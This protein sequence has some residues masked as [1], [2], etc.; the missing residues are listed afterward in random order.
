MTKIEAD[1]ARLAE[2]Y[3]R[4]FDTSE[5]VLVLADL[6]ERTAHGQSAFLPGCPDW[7]PAYRNGAQMTFQHILNMLETKTKEHT[8]TIKK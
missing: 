1:A 4:L 6:R 2:A 3:K 5:G 8:T 7:Q